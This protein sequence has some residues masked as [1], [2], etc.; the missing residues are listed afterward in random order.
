[1]RR[2]DIDLVVLDARDPATALSLLSDWRGDG[3]TAPA[4]LVAADAGDVARCLE[5]GADEC[6]SAAVDSRELGARL[7]VLVRRRRA[8]KPALLEAYDLRIDT[9]R[10]T[11]ERAGRRIDLTPREY[12]ILEYLALHRGRVVSRTELYEHLRGE[13]EDTL[14][15]VMD[16][17]VAGIRKKLDPQLVTTKRGHGYCI[18]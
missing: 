2:P 14:S 4:V 7:K 11:V 9:A 5:G 15:N 17:H 6:V 10:K 13:N 8:A 12:A 3:L 16:V 18:D 1:V